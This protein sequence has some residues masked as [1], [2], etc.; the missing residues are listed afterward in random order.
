MAETSTCLSP[1]CGISVEGDHKKCP[2]CGWAMRSARSIRTRGWVLLACG[3]FLVLVMGW[4]GWSLLP[5]LLRPGVDYD[6]SRF[7]GDRDQ[8]RMILGLFALVIG[9]GLLGSVNATYM[10]V[11]GRQNRLFVILTL[12]LA[13]ILIVCAW[14]MTRMFKGA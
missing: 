12:V 2:K 1:L 13:V 8:A 9:F 7:S 6:G 4:I 10:I 3:L 14:L 5:T 11:T